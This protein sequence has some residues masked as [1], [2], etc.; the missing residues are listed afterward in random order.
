MH[1][2][3]TPQRSAMMSRIGGRNTAPEIAIRLRLHARGYRYRL[4]VRRLPGSP[5]IVL[6]KHHAVIFVHGC[7]WH[8]HEQCRFTATPKS[9]PQF[10]QEKF[11]KN[12][13]RDARNLQAL[14]TSGWRIAI[15]WE[16]AIK[17]SAD[18]TAQ[19]VAQWIESGSDFIELGEHD[20]H[21]TAP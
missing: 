18:D 21:P 19:R 13:T 11:Q 12:V 20:L 1:P 6:P 7:F 2:D 8:R 15:I 17:S 14:K 10:W 5:D 4:N 9:N 16:C 3:T